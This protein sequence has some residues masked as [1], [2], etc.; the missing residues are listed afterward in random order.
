MVKK[1]LSELAGGATNKIVKRISKIID[2]ND[3][4]KLIKLGNVDVKV[5]RAGKN[6][7]TEEYIPSFKVGKTVN[8]RD[9]TE[10]YVRQLQRQIDGL[11]NM[12]PNELLDNLDSV[13]RG[14][15]AQQEAREKYEARLYKRMLEEETKP[16]V[17]KE[18]AEAIAGSR[19]RNSMKSLAALHEPDIVA[20][21]KDVIGIAED[22]L[23]SMGNKYVNSSIGS[24]W[25]HRQDDLIAYAREAIKNGKGDQP[26]NISFVLE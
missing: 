19:T 12:T 25:R 1:S 11:N 17:S 18:T 16:G 13:K 23:P 7:E 26:L 9:K 22:G 20:G 4:K 24:Q 15:Y 5:T 3:G 2:L 10:E 6:L 21:G 14:G 8:L